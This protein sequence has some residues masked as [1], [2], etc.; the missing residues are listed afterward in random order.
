MTKEGKLENK[1]Y[2]KWKYGDKKWNLPPK[3]Q[4]GCIEDDSTGKVLGYE[5]PLQCYVPNL[6]P[7]GVALHRHVFLQNK[8]QSKTQLWSIDRDHK[9]EFLTLFQDDGGLAGICNRMEL[10]YYHSAIPSP[11]L[12]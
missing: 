2:K 3:F 6:Q 9:D 12:L 1:R 10:I 4:K 5:E 8:T 7:I 11:P